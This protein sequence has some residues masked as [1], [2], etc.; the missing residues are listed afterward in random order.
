MHAA[1]QVHESSESFFS[2][3][4]ESNPGCIVLSVRQYD[5]KATDFLEQTLARNKHAQIIL[6][7]CNWS[8]QHVVHS[9]QQGFADF[10]DL[11]SA[12]E[13]TLTTLSMA[14]RRDHLSREEHRFDFPQ[15]VSD[16][17]NAEEAEIFRLIIRGRTTKE[18]SAELALSVRT[19]HY[20]KS[21]IFSKLG[22]HHRNEAFEIVRK[23]WHDRHGKLPLPHFQEVCESDKAEN[24]EHQS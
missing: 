6:N 4:D 15:T 5:K 18:I 9:I 21:A 10:F 12:A 1:L 16:A 13:R 17:L 3:Y 23:V 2:R 8:V 11:N 19:I 24:L 14:I 20:R 22:I 7:V